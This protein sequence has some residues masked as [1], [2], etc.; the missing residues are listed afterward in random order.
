MKQK[1]EICLTDIVFNGLEHKLFFME[2]LHKCEDL[3]NDMLALIYCLGIDEQ[4]RNHAN[5]FFNFATGVLNVNC[6]QENWQNNGSLRV[7]RLAF[8]LYTNRTI[9]VNGFTKAE[10]QLLECQKYS[11]DD[12]FCCAYAKYFWQAIQIKYPCYCE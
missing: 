3:G 7:I 8:N 2:N 6:L 9:S 10:E 1:Q 5:E 12:I 11:V 4:V